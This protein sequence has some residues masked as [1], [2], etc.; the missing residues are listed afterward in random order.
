MLSTGTCSRVRV[1]EAVSADSI[2][3]GKKTLS[4]L[5]QLF[6]QWQTLAVHSTL[7]RPAFSAR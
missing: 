1:Y 6:Y 7:N 4:S 5:K 2:Q 3:S